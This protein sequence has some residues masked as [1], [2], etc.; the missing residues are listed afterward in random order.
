MIKWPVEGVRK[1]NVVSSDR[2]SADFCLILPGVKPKIYVKIKMQNK[3]YL[4][5]HKVKLG[6][7]FA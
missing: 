7:S 1:K 3:T 5:G 4:K 2:V 6:M